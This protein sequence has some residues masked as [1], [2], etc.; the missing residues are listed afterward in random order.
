[1]SA[2]STDDRYVNLWDLL[3]DVPTCLSKDEERR[4]QGE[5][6]KALL[7]N[8]RRVDGQ[9]LSLEVDAHGWTITVLSCF[10]TP[11]SPDRY[12]LK[13]YIP[14]DRH[15][16]IRFE[17]ED[18]HKAAMYQRKWKPGKVWKQFYKF[19]GRTRVFT[20]RMDK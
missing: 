10:A 3:T 15:E 11:M 9:E 17:V 19:I 18:G 20:G 1:M 13:V 2:I 14:K 12:L 16:A 5:R 4:L 6:V 8:A 7:N